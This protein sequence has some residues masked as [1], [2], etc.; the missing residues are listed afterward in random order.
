MVLT[1]ALINN[2]VEG[3]AEGYTKTLRYCW[4]WL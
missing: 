1:R 2:M 4:C 3:V